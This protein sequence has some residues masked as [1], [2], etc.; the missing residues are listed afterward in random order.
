V[1]LTHRPPKARRAAKKGVDGRKRHP[2]VGT[3]GPAVPRAV[4]RTVEAADGD[5]ARRVVGGT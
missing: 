5:A 2:P 4:A 3:T 1:P